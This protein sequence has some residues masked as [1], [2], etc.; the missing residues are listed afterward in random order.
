MKTGFYLG[1]WPP[2][3]AENYPELPEIAQKC[4]TRAQANCL[5]LPESSPARYTKAER[6]GVCTSNIL[7]T[8]FLFSSSHESFWADRRH[9]V[10]ECLGLRGVFPEFFEVRFAWK[11]KEKNTK[12]SCPRL[13]LPNIGDQ[14]T[15]FCYIPSPAACLPKELDSNLI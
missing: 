10:K 14:P 12:M 9:L 8:F 7:G 13:G 1:F 11:I 3:I 4:L 15:F 6:L 5:E 2:K